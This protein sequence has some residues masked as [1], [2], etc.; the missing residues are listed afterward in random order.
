MI[1]VLQNDVPQSDFDFRGCVSRGCCSVS[2]RKP[3]F[4]GAT[5]EGISV[6]M[7]SKGEVETCRKEL[8]RKGRFTTKTM[9]CPTLC[10]AQAFAE[11]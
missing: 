7:R 10:G 2:F 3:A 1:Y 8:L 11:H 5:V 4:W 6:E 9:D